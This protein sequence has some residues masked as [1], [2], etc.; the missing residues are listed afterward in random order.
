MGTRQ[1]HGFTIIEISLFVAISG[2]LALGLLTGWSVAINGQ[3]YKDSV[4]SLY[5]YIQQQYSL[6]YSVENGRTSELGC[7]SA[8]V[9]ENGNIPRG[10]SDC[11]LLGRYLRLTNGNRFE[12][13]AVI[14]NETTDMEGELSEYQPKVVEQQIGLSQSEFVVPWGAYLTEQGSASALN[15][16]IAIIRSPSTGTVYS[17]ITDNGNTQN[18][19]DVVADINQ[20]EQY[21]CVRPDTGTVSVSGGLQAIYLPQFSASLN[22]VETIAEDSGC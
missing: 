15:I 22:S 11:V 3:R 8:G 7:N 4:D 14:G 21:L 18:L 1:Q 2:L 19:S 20:T 5:A 6:V 12:S 9:D 13:F 17:Y 16:G 10:Q